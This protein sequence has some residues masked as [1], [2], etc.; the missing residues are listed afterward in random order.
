M[1]E[2]RVNG[3]MAFLALKEAI[4]ADLSAGLFANAVHAKHQ[5]RLGVGYRQFLKYLKRYRLRDAAN[6]SSA[7]ARAPLSAADRLPPVPVPRVPGPG[8]E[9]VN[10]RRAPGR[11]FVFNPADIDPKKLV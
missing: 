2:H 10:A 11:K 8:C 9:P 3:R 7:P 4:A 6:F 5:G 1:G